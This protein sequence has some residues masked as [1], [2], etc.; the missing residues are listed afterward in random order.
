MML[1]SSHPELLQNARLELSL[2]LA[3]SS[4]TFSPERLERIK[5]LVQSQP[6]WGFL[7]K[8]AVQHRLVPLLYLGLHQACPQDL[9]QEIEHYLNRH[10]QVNTLKNL[11]LDQKCQ[12]ILE[13]FKSAQIPAIA[14]KGPTL[15]K[16]VYGSLSLRQFTD[17]D[18]LVRPQDF[19]PA[20]TLLNAKG[21]ESSVNLGWEASVC[22]LDH[23]INIDL[24]RSL[25]PDFFGMP[26]N[27]I[28]PND[29]SLSPE[30]LLVLLAIQFG[31]D[32]CHWKVCLGQL[33]DIA[34]L[35]NSYPDLNFE[36]VYQRA[37]SLGALRF[38]WISLILVQDLLE[39]EL[40]P[41]LKSQLPVAGIER[42]LAQWVC[43]R[44]ADNTDHPTV[45]PEDAGFWYFLAVYNHRFYL[46]VRERWPDKIRY[47][48]HWTW[49]IIRMSLKPNK[50]DRA[51]IDLPR[52]LHFF[53][54]F[55]HIGRLLYKY[56]LKWTR[57]SM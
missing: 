50:A 40:P 1:T 7:L 11:F 24:H 55:I 34:A 13:W 37:K 38:L 8:A 44:I 5:F 52:G 14:Y 56:G 23:P 47:C 20:L 30:S 48:G 31:K 19:E 57:R 28:D 3:C 12:E 16:Q 26:D 15:A 21:F 22:S 2:L 54:L 27:C 51:L 33:C 35:L 49:Q 53:Y 29:E 42:K 4:P 36:W 32:C 9:P 39:I 10:C 46:Q 45:I 17:L 41:M 18:F 43:E 25:V 6:D